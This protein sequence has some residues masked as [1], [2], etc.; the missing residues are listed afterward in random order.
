MKHTYQ[1]VLV[2]IW[3][4]GFTECTYVRD[5]Y[6]GQFQRNKSR[7]SHPHIV[8][9][10]PQ[11]MNFTYII[12]F[13]A[14]VLNRMLQQM[15]SLPLSALESHTCEKPSDQSAKLAVLQTAKEMGAIVRN[16][17]DFRDRAYSKYPPLYTYVYIY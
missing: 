1:R 7:N 6:F 8:V 4:N 17:P 3:E 15:D 10:Y 12:C 2:H 14:F 11:S 13:F 5:G 9:I 16:A